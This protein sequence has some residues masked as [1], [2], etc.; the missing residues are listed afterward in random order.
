MNVLFA[1]DVDYLEQKD[2]DELAEQANLTHK[3]LQGFLQKT[4]SFINPKS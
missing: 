4:K 1:K 3:L 2:F